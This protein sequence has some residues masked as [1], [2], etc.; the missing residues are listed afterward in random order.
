MKTEEFKKEMKEKVKSEVI[1]QLLDKELEE[2]TGGTGKSIHENTAD[3][4]KCG[5]ALAMS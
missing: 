5:I 1:D 2:V 4:C 3:S